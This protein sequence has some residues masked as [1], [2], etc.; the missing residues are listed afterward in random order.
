M[1]ENTQ[2][3]GGTQHEHEWVKE[4]P[5]AVRGRSGTELWIIHTCETDECP[6]WKKTPLY[7][8]YEV[9]A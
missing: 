5:A 1:P 4:G 2:S 7:G 9:E 8:D 3:G 6:A